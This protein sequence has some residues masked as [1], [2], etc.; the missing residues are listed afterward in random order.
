MQILSTNNSIIRLKLSYQ[1]N[2][3]FSK[4]TDIFQQHIPY[5]IYRQ[6]SSANFYS[7]FFPPGRCFLKTI[8]CIQYSLLLIENYSQV[9]FDNLRQSSLRF[10]NIRIVYCIHGYI[11]PQN[12]SW[13]Q[14]MKLNVELSEPTFPFHTNIIPLNQKSKQKLFDKFLQILP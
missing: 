13:C 1:T 8:K 14:I 2:R 5:N 12:V 7:N 9:I 6:T 4:W 11:S 3:H 10:D